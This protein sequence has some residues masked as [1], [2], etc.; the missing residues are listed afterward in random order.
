MN[1]CYKPLPIT[2]VQG[3]QPRQWWLRTM[4]TGAQCSVVNQ[5]RTLELRSD[6]QNQAKCMDF[7]H[8]PLPIIGV[9]VNMPYL[10]RTQGVVQPTP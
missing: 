8:K 9:H 4:A 10:I 7:C 1:F 6:K 5:P 2:A 3:P